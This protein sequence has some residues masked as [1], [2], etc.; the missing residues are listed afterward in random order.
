ML[1]SGLDGLLRHRLWVLAVVLLLTLPAIYALSGLESEDTYEGWFAPDDPV[2]RFYREFE[3]RFADDD[4]FV[5]V[6]RDEKLFSRET[7]RLIAGLTERVERLPYV[8]EVTSLTSVEHLR[9]GENALIVEPLVPDPQRADPEIIRRKALAEPLYRGFLISEDG[10]ST[11]IF[12]ELEGIYNTTQEK[13]LYQ[14]LRA[15]VQEYEEKT[16]RSFYLGGHVILD[17]AI[18][19]ASE[20]DMRTFIP[21]TVGL[22]F[23]VLWGV[24]R[25]ASFA[26]LAFVAVSLALLWTFGLY[27]GTG[28]KYNM[29][30]SIL[31]TI[32]LA[33][34]I[35]DAVH[36]L[37]HYYEE[38][39]RRHPRGKALRLTMRRMLRPCLF[40]TLTTG[41]GF[42]SFLSSDIPVVRLTGLF[43]ALGIGIA[44]VL[45]VLVLPAT[46][47]FL[48]PPTGTARKQSKGAF[49]RFL[50][51]LARTTVDRHKLVLWGAVGV[52]ILGI[53]GASRLEA[54]TLGLKWLRDDHPLQRSYA[55]IEENLTGL[56]NL[57]LIVEGE[58][59]AL[60]SP[61]VLRKLEELAAFALEQQGV[62]KT[63]SLV[64]Y[65]KR[66][67]Q[68]LHGDDPRFYRIPDTAREIAQA[69]LLYEFSGGGELRERVSGDYSAGRLTVITE[70][71]PSRAY[72][73]LRE[74][75]T[76]YA[77]E[78][79]LS[80][81][82]TGTVVLVEA[83]L[84]KLT[85][86]QIK[87]LA[88]ALV[89]ITLLMI[90]L[91]RSWK[92]GLLSLIPNGLPI[93]LMFAVMGL[94]GIPLDAATSTVAGMA[95][96]IAVDDTIHFLTRFRRELNT[97]GDYRRALVQTSRTVGQAI[98]FTSVILLAGFSVLTLGTFKGTI[99]F[100]LLIGLTMLFALVGDLVLLPVL[101]LRLRP[102]P[103]EAPPAAAPVPTAAAPSSRSHP[104]EDPQ[105]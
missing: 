54:E 97:S 15:L 3:R 84:K 4:F 22:L 66:I 42:I 69:L 81:K 64:D 28:Q 17:V 46:V 76:D 36:I 53:L 27:A 16:G 70:A 55:F 68:A 6:F 39:A 5:I 62:R 40:T 92:L 21:F 1:Q 56:Y 20:R 90:A 51:R 98:A 95:L 12:A 71:L 2:Y 82:A 73:A 88:L 30:M 43:A 80:V 47:S 61:E 94:F 26:A 24:F 96:G 60:R 59:D 41:A 52:F 79:G 48:R 104:D 38:L 75:L 50:E 35:A 103:V 31:P 13:E 10:T 72:G 78:L 29:M 25:R 102:L 18:M 23:T 83:M 77:Q 86:S 67:N 93:L 19:E 37:V 100:G 91:L 87:S 14:K 65:V 44:F 49:A 32:V 105:A 7:L 58:R 89:L 34:G 33:I 8:R 63:I 85:L 74:T 45:T 57:E 99:Y 11:A 9:G 101:L